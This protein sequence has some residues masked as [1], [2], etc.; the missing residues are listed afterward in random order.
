MPDVI[1]T[2]LLE[3]TSV[4]EV[5][6]EY[7]YNT[8]GSGGSTSDHGGGGGNDDDWDNDGVKNWN[9]YK[10][11]DP[12]VRT[13]NDIKPE[14]EDNIIKI[15]NKQNNDNNN[16]NS[17]NSRVICTW[18]HSKGLFSLEDYT[19]DVNYSMENIS[20]NTKLG[21]WLWAIDLV[22]RLEK[23]YQRNNWYDK[24]VIGFWKYGTQARADQIKK[25][26]GLT[27]KGNLLGKFLRVVM[28]PA[29]YVLGTLLK[30][31]VIRKYGDKLK[32]WELENKINTSEGKL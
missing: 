2:K 11:H 7:S 22:D 4:R 15:A 25:D 9:D 29:C 8:G 21:Y 13:L 32:M 20:L 28:E 23:R 18:L 30:P 10:P 27:N 31:Y 1:E 3:E 24:L 16:N 19:I 5:T 26:M 12:Q 6:R 14:Y 17:S